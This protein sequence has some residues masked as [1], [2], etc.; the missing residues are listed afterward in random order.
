MSLI[1][2]IKVPNIG[3]KDSKILFIGESPGAE[4]EKNKE[5]FY[6]TSEKF[7]NA[8]KLFM[9]VL[10]RNGL[11]REEVRLFNLSQYRP[12]ENKF[13][14]LLDSDEL[15]EGLKD[16]EDEIIN[17]PPVLIV[18]LGA[19]PLEYI[20][21]K[22]GIINYR[23]SILSLSRNNV[24]IKCIPTL[25]PSFVNRNRSVY[26][27]FDMDMQ[28][29]V[30][31]SLF[32]E[33]RLPEREVVLLNSA[34]KDLDE[35][36][37]LLLDAPYLSVDIETFGSELACIGFASS[38]KRGI[39]IF[40]DGTVEVINA[41]DRLLSSNIPKVLH[42]A[43]FDYTYLTNKQFTVNNIHHCTFQGQRVL[44][45]EL[46]R[47]LAYLT[48]EVTR[49]PYYK[50]ELAEAMGD[51]KSWN[52]KLGID[53]L[54][55]YNGKDICCTAEI[56]EY[57]KQEF[58]N[59]K[60]DNLKRIFA[61]DIS[62]LELARDISLTGFLV[63]KERRA[64]LRVALIDE[65]VDHQNK[66]NK[67]C[68]ITYDINKELIGSILS[69]KK[70]GSEY[71]KLL[72]ICGL[73]CNSP[74]AVA[75]YLYSYLQL[76]PRFNKTGGRT[77]D[78]DSMIATLTYC[79]NQTEK[80]KSEDKKM[81]MIKNFLIVKFIV[82]IR[83]IRKKLSNYIDYGISDDGRVRALFAL[84]AETGRWTCYK[85]LDDTGMNMQTIPRDK[86]KVI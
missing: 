43:T 60:D 77:T 48:S 2:K 69:T 74:K 16:I 22:Y 75:D 17:N 20:L 66:L 36:V 26:P 84:A 37:K 72:S 5:P 81:E 73:N 7:Q 14:Y 86:V 50:M 57:Q 24:N 1:S 64:L 12:Q 47:T 41:Y 40:N 62:Q 32:P 38:P 45:P 29:I 18:P 71:K 83:Q 25:H 52:R 58:I 80:F 67:L 44:E 33:L 4:E 39:S 54:M 53:N 23:G 15:K 79:K 35:H 34:S 21:G 59:R 11:Q 9:D 28:R 63:D 8:G 30:G 10:R 82:I 19:K 68:G 27:I 76:P 70:T 65:W 46:P 51:I 49:E 31:D 55:R 42:F 6:P 85:F 78:E 56:Y 61:F 13:E 3:P